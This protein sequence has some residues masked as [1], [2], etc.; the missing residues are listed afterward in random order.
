MLPLTPHKKEWKTKWSP[1]LHP[2]PPPD[3]RQKKQMA[4]LVV[5]VRAQRVHGL[6]DRFVHNLR[7]G[8]SPLLQNIDLRHHSGHVH[9]RRERV[10]GDVLLNSVLAHLL[11]DLYNKRNGNDSKFE[12]EGQ[13]GN[14][15]M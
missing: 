3:V 10:E 8:V 12:I 5:H 1:L 15:G 6:D 14:S 4:H 2:I 9:A 7:V 13:E 11:S